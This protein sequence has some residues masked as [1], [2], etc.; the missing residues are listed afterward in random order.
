MKTSYIPGSSSTQAKMMEEQPMCKRTASPSQALIQE[1]GFNLFPR[2]YPC[3]SDEIKT[4]G[5]KKLANPDWGC[6]ELVH[7]FFANARMD[8]FE[9]ERSV[10]KPTYKAWFRGE[11]IDYSAPAIRYLLILPKCDPYRKKL[12]YHEMLNPPLH[13]EI[14]ETIA[15]P[16]ARWQRDGGSLLIKHLTSHEIGRAHV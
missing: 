9:K 16:G 15:I 4:R 2:V 14:L 5:W 10:G 11:W 7:E 12:S 1:R 13:E 3:F 6:H 8:E